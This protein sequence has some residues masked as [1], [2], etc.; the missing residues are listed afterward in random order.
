[1]ALTSR[2]VANIYAKNGTPLENSL[3][4]V[5]GRQNYF[6]NSGNLFYAAPATAVFNGVTCN[7]VIEVFPNGLN[8]NSDKYFA[9]ETP[10]QLVT[11][12][13]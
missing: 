7:S 10:A 2:I 4:A 3:G 6:S 1:M 8:V 9:V 12:G 11:N 13:I 5:N